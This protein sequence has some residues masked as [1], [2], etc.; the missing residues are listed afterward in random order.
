MVERFIV[1][2]LTEE[3]LKAII[4][5]YDKRYER[6]FKIYNKYRRD[7][8]L[9]PVFIISAMLTIFIISSLVYFRIH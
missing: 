1:K 2:R 5:S 6:L 9:I 4:N 7:I 8:L 3:E